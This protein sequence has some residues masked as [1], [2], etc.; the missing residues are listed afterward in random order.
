MYPK[1]EDART[2]KIPAART[3]KHDR[4]RIERFQVA[5]LLPCFIISTRA[6]KEKKKKKKKKKKTRGIFIIPCT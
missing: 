6:K 5:T 4:E 2:S 1:R 3:D